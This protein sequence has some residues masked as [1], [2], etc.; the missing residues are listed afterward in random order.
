[1]GEQRLLPVGQELLRVVP[2]LLQHVA[3]PL[4]ARVGEELGV[5]RDEALLGL[6]GYVWGVVWG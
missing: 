1:M 4:P 6:G 3:P 2:L 5:V